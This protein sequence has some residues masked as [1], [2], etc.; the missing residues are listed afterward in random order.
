[1]NYGAS[2]VQREMKEASLYY[3]Y[4]LPRVFF[5]LCSFLFSEQVIPPP[6]P[7]CFPSFSLLCVCLGYFCVS[8]CVC[9]HV[10]VR[11]LFIFFL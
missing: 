7:I 2:L 4:I 1:M 8:V 5:S 11:T 10:F 3:Y 9:V 6:N